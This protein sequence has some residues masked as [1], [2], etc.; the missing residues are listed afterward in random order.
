MMFTQLITLFS[1]KKKNVS[2]WD[3]L[4][5][6]RNT[7]ISGENITIP[8]GMTLILPSISFEGELELKGE[9]YVL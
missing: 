3:V 8:N 9:G 7:F 5:F 2:I 6:K 4:L 1:G